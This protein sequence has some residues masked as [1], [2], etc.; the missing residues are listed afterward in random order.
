MERKDDTER[1]RERKGEKKRYRLAVDE[2]IGIH[3]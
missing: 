1:E 3:G 2:E